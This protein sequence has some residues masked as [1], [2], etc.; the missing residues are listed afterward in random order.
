VVHLKPV[1]WEKAAEKYKNA[2]LKV[3]LWEEVL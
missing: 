2:E 3:K 1:V